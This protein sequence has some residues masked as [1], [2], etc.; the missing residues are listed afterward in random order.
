M[1]ATNSTVDKRAFAVLHLGARLHYAVPAILA[2]AG[3]L[4][5]FYTDIT[6]SDVPGSRILSSR[7]G[8]PVPKPLSRLLGRQLPADL[9]PSRVT[10]L[11]FH[12]LVLALQ[13][14]RPVL[15]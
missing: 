3:M 12:S 13:R 1:I 15:S 7:Q 8:L 10:S 6:A 11:P 5:R 9:P 2:R 14:N 4:A